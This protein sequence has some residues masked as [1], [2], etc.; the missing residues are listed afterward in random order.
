MG[1]SWGPPEAE[2]SL[3][4]LPGNTIKVLSQELGQ[5]KSELWNICD[6]LWALAMA[7]GACL[8]AMDAASPGLWPTERLYVAG[9]RARIHITPT[10][11]ASAAA[12]AIHV[13]YR[14][15]ARSVDLVRV[16]GLICLRQQVL[17]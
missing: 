1:I 4:G 11:R 16:I 7:L 9:E 12:S 10:T 6:V 14:L 3:P 8:T 13:Q 17:R 15:M 5:S 2:E